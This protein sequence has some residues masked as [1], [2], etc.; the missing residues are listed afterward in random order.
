MIFYRT[1]CLRKFNCC[2]RLYVCHFSGPISVK[3]DASSTAFQF[4]SEGV[5][6]ETRCSQEYLDHDMLVVGYGELKGQPYWLV[7]NSWAVTWG[8]HGYIL[9]SRNASNQCGIASRAVFPLVWSA[10]CYWTWLLWSLIGLKRFEW[11]WKNSTIIKNI[12]YLFLF[13]LWKLIAM[14]WMNCITVSLKLSAPCRSW[15]FVLRLRK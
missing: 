12:F 15:K 13:L 10:R 2:A 7:K 9:M 1:S 3:V 5:L 14:Q 4:Y 8:S 6:N 11:L